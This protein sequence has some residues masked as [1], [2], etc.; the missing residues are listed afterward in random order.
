MALSANEKEAI[1]A[2][3]GESA[4]APAVK[5]KTRRYDVRFADGKG[6]TVLDM[7]GDDTAQCMAGIASIFRDGYVLSV[8][9]M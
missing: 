3:R 9:P 2:A 7:N 5:S 4:A 1:M 6:A 8:T